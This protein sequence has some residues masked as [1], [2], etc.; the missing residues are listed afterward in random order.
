MIIKKQL[1]ERNLEILKENRI[2]LQWKSY[3]PR[4]LP[5]SI[6]FEDDTQVEPYTGFHAGD[7]LCSMGAFSY[8]H[9]RLP[10]GMKVG[11]YCAISWSLNITGPRHPYEWFTTSN[12]TYDRNAENIKSYLEDK[13]ISIPVHD[14]RSLD[15]SMPVI[16]NDVWIGQNVTINRG[17]K[18]GDGAV[19]AAFSVVTK[20]VPSFTIVG[21]NPAKVIKQRF[22]QEIIS[23]LKLIEWWNYEPTNFMSLDIKNIEQFIIDFRDNVIGKEKYT[24]NKAVLKDILE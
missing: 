8:S 9:S 22:P 1:T 16:G 15:K 10:A 4:N 11:R 18:I 24:P 7:S 14:P 12:I 21:G 6:H 2:S 23:Q 20:D 3:Q 17:V 13:E 5:D 19:I